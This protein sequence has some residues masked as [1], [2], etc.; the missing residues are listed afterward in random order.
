MDAELRDG[1]VEGLER[2]RGPR[3]HDPALHHREDEPGEL[4]AVELA[5]QAVAGVVEP[6]LDRGDPVLE[7]PVVA[8]SQPMLPPRWPGH[9]RD[10]L[11][12]VARE[13]GVSVDA[14][15]RVGTL[16][17]LQAYR[18][19][20]EIGLNNIDELRTREDEEPLP[21]GQGQS[22]EPLKLAKTAAPS[23]AP[24]TQEAS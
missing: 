3:L 16:E 4:G 2:A 15:L 11:D 10:F 17:R 5:R 6:A 7:V 18:I 13:C 19:A 14:L 24:T 9:V 23:T 12:V 22:Y 20:R 21:D 8:R 1:R